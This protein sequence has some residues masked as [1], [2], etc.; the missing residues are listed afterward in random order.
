MWNMLV[1][2]IPVVFDALGTVP[3]DL[4]RGSEHLEIGGRIETI[5]VKALLRLA[6]IL[7]GVLTSE[8][9]CCHSDSREK[10]P[11]TSGMLNS[12]GVK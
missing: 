8:E 4:E 7:K 11:V 5:R 2:V 12:H 3:K 10:P 9:T 1:T 6:R